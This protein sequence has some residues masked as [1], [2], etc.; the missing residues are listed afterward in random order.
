MTSLFESILQNK[1]YIGC[2]VFFPSVCLLFCVVDW[3][4]QQKNHKWKFD[5]IRG[6]GDL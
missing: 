3:G 6:M 2:G 1:K 5:F 4:A